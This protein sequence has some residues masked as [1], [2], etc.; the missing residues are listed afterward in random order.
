MLLQAE[1]QLHSAQK[2]TSEADKNQLRASL[3]ALEQQVG[4]ALSGSASIVQL[5]V[6]WGSRIFSTN[7]ESKCYFDWRVDILSDERVQIGII[8]RKRARRGVHALEPQADH[9]AGAG[10]ADGS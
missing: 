3:R 4:A 9:D 6:K 1:Q 5:A 8:G 7:R 10:A 2:E